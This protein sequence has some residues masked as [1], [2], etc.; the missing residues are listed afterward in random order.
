M[1][2]ADRT[3]ACFTV[4]KSYADLEVQPSLLLEML[5]ALPRLPL[6]ATKFLLMVKSL[7]AGLSSLAD[8]LAPTRGADT[9]D[10]ALGTKKSVLIKIGLLLP[11]PPAVVCPEQ[12]VRH[13]N[14]HRLLERS[15]N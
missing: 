8:S 15:Q 12:A 10:D 3:A 5:L 1:S 11:S 2:W 7:L 6:G 13:W 9:D 4:V 14:M